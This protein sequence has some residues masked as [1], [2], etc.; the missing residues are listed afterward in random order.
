MVRRV[1]VR[2][3]RSERGRHSRD[4]PAQRTHSRTARRPALLARCAN[5]KRFRILHFATH[6]DVDLID[7]YRSALILA[8]DHLPDGL[9]AFRKGEKVYD[10]RLTVETIL[11]EWELDADLVV[12]SACQTA[13]GKAAEG[14][15]LLGFAQAFLQKGARSVL[16]SRWKVDDTA[17]ALFMLRFYENALG[18]RKELQEPL[19]RAAAL[20]EA[21]AWLRNL[22]RADAE[23]LAVGL[24][25]GV[26]RGTERDDLPVVK[27]KANLPAGERP[28]AHP[29]YWASFVLIGDPN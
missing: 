8:Q 14:E 10:G 7:P 24:T 15:G 11:R 6:G 25:G 27:A 16:L 26:L 21:R 28:F 4:R 29:F 12:L 18:K 2:R 20:A 17:T 19:G 5:G 13:L 22:S 23:R 9:E 1:C 3:D